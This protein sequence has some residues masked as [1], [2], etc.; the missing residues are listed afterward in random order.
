MIY[1]PEDF[2]YT[3]SANVVSFHETKPSQVYTH[4]ECVNYVLDVLWFEEDIEHVG[5]FVY[6]TKLP[7]EQTE[8]LLSELGFKKWT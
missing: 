5:G 4:Q 1:T 3:V 7:K 8:K 2:W 6:K